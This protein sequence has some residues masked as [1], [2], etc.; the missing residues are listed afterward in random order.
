M[1]AN[2]LNADVFII[3]TAVQNVCIDF[4]KPNELKLHEI[5]VKELKKLRDEG[6]FAP[7]SMLPKIEAA[8]QFLE[9]GGSKAIITS[10]DNL[11]KAIRGEAGTI[12]TH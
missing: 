4:G 10:P 5:T 3:S 9:K 2:L 11:Q 7:G 12:I 6:H 1:L 8:L